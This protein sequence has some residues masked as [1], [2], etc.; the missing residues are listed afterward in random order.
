MTEG[1]R[2]KRHAARKS[3]ITIT[4]KP[5]VKNTIGIIITVTNARRKRIVIRR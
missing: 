4:V 1:I 2:I 5:G 3:D